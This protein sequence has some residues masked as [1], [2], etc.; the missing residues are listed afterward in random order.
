MQTKSEIIFSSGSMEWETPQDLFDK[1][2]DEFHLDLDV[3][4]SDE[5]AKLPDYFTIE[6]DA[7]S[8]DWNGHRCWCNPP[9]GRQ[10]EKWVKKASESD[11]VVM[12]IPARTDTKWFHEYV[13]HKAEIRFI[14][15]RVKYLTP[16]HG[17]AIANC[18]FPSMIVIFRGDGCR[19]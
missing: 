4:A 1:I 15:G 8:Q 2:Q 5:N 9:Y 14:K 13:Y 19:L 17:K 12:L 7:L 18:P 6:D 11:F 3:C 10:I 16:G